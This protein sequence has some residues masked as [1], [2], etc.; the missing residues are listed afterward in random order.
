[1]RGRCVAPTPDCMC[2]AIQDIRQR[3]FLPWAL[4]S[5]GSECVVE[6]IRAKHD[7]YNAGNAATLIALHATPSLHAVFWWSS[8]GFDRLEL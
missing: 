2:R 5:R 6:K 3:G 8:E 4:C 7:I 1:M